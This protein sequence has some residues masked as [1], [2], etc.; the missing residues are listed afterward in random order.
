MEFLNFLREEPVMGWF[1]FLA[2]LVTVVPAASVLRRWIFR[3]NQAEVKKQTA[4]ETKS[5]H[6]GN[7]TELVILFV[8]FMF[9][10]AVIGWIRST[11]FG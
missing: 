10:L 4:P 6:F 1:I 11:F 9:L 8:G 3:R 5:T 2:L 7:R